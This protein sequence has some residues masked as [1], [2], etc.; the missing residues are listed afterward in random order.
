MP[1]AAEVPLIETAHLP[2]WM[3]FTAGGTK[4]FSP[5][6]L[7]AF[8][9]RVT[10]EKVSHGEIGAGDRLVSIGPQMRRP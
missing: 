3:M 7:D 10:V 8:N 2:V 5:S 1:Y 6:V 4:S 9:G